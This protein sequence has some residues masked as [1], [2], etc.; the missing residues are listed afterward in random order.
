MPHGANNKRQVASSN[1]QASR[2][3]DG[4]TGQNASPPRLSAG[5]SGQPASQPGQTAGQP[6]QKTGQPGQKAG[7][8]GQTAG[9]T[10]QTAGQPGQTLDQQGRPGG[11]PNQQA[12]QN[13]FEAKTTDQTNVE[14]Q[15]SHVL[16][17]LKTLF[18]AIVFPGIFSRFLPARLKEQCH[19]M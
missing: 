14:T 9:Q 19:E 18:E 7:Q 5:Q 11:Q 4:H 12:N 6:G 13:S 10:G 17:Q 2:Q 8:P 3:Q 16:L 1:G 15:E